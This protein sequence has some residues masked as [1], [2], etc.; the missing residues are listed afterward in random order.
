VKNPESHAGTYGWA[1]LVAGVIVFDIVSP[2]TLSSA[3]DRYLEDPL[4]RVL[5]IGAVA[6][7]ALHVLNAFDNYDIPD[8]IHAMSSAATNL[9]EQLRERLGH[10]AI[11]KAQ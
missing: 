8:P 5:A 1:G 11:N 10:G 4:K 9:S 2:E 7:T 6:V 3:A